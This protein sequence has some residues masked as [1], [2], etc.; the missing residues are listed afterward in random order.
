M[1]GEFLLELD[2]DA[3]LMM[4]GAGRFG[5]H[6]HEGDPVGE[7]FRLGRRER[8][9][10]CHLRRQ[11]EG[12]SLSF[13][14]EEGR[15]AGAVPYLEMPLKVYEGSFEMEHADLLKETPVDGIV[16]EAFVLQT[17]QVEDSSLGFEHL[18]KNLVTVHAQLLFSIERVG[19]KARFLTNI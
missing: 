14:F 17:A 6:A 12:E 5:H 15:D 13:F 19:E 4:K 1:E 7:S 8:I 10:C 16:E 18:P 9:R 3:F 2:D 11:R